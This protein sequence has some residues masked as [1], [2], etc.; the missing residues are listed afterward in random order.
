MRRWRRKAAVP[1]AVAAALL[2]TAGCGQGIDDGAT[3]E[4]TGDDAAAETTEAVAS[5]GEWPETVTYGLLPTEDSATLEA[6]YEPFEGYMSACLDHP[7]ELFTGTN[8]TAMIEAMRGGNIQVAKFGPF[9]YILAAERAGAEALIQELTL[10]GEAFYTSQFAA[11]ESNGLTSLS[12]LEGEPLAFVDAASTSGHLFPRAMLIEDVGI[13]NDEIEDWLGEIIFSGGHDA[14]L[15]AVLNGDVMAAPVSSV[16][17]V[18]QIDEGDLGDHPNVDDLTVLA[19]T[20]QIPR[21][22]EAVQ[23]DLPD[24]LKTAIGDCFLG[25]ADDQE[26]TEFLEGFS[27]GYTEAEDSNYDVVRD[28]AAALDMSPED[29]LEE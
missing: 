13:T 26:L 8:Y 1:A 3:A 14:S 18:R 10:E 22:V 4:T 19:E 15:L 16:A 9:S 17:W 12:D 28:T 23:G 24:D 7:F 25:V 5:N 27:A 11:L 20:S 2:V 6:R 21:T 29:L